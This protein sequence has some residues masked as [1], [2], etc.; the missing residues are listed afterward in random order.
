VRRG[1]DLLVVTFGNGVRMSLRAAGRLA[2]EGI[3][4]EILDLQ[5]LSPLPEEALLARARDH[6]AILV[7]DET[8]R[9]GGVAQA[10]MATLV[11]GGFEGELAR[12]ASVDSFIPLGPAASHVLLDDSEIEEAARTLARPGRGR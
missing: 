7:A 5:W 11:D 12:V 10:V 2:R 6:R 4:C 8:R 9:S 3:D 1:S